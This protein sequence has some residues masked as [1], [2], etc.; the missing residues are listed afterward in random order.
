MLRVEKMDWSEIIKNYY[1]TKFNDGRSKLLKSK[2]Y[3]KIGL[4]TMMSGVMVIGLLAGCGGS[5][6]TVTEKVTEKVTVTA[7]ATGGTGS[8]MGNLV[9]YGDTVANVGCLQSN[10]VHRG[11]LFIFRNRVVDPKTGKDMLAEDLT[12]VQVVLPDTKI[13]PLV[14]K[15]G[16]HGTDPDSDSF[17]AVAWEVPL[18][19]PTGSL[20]YEVKVVGKDG[21]TGAW[22]PFGLLTSRLTVAPFDAKFVRNWS[23]NIT[24]TG[25]SVATLSISQGAK[26]TF[27]NRDAIPHKVVGDGWDSGDLAAAVGTTYKTFARTFDQPGTFVV[28]DAANP[29]L[30]VTITVNATS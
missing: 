30:I 23:V 4:A 2:S 22:K 26:V 16:K 9:V 29:A 6:A 11:E 24:A 27:S 28:K 7:P 17:W 3:A 14:S 13:A 25:M 21:R 12:S 18:N 20:G 15:Y 10:I 1:A 5:S 19:Y 8:V